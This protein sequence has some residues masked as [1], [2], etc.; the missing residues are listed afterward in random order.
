MGTGVPRY[1]PVSWLGRFST[2]KL[3]ENEHIS[4]PP[5]AC[6]EELGYSPKF[7]LIGSKFVKMGPTGPVLINLGSGELWDALG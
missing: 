1:L 4:S 3:P 5:G 6:M 7:T 2:G